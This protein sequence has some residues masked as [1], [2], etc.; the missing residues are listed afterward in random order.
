MTSSEKD[1]LRPISREEIYG[2]VG[3]PTDVLK[4]LVPPFTTEL[5]EA[6]SKG[7]EA[8]QRKAELELIGTGDKPQVLRYKIERPGEGLALKVTMEGDWRDAPEVPRGLPILADFEGTF[9]RRMRPD[10]DPVAVEGKTLEKD[11]AYAVAQQG[12]TNIWYL[13]LPPN[14]FPNGGV[15]TKFVFPDGI[16]VIRGE[17]ILLY[18]DPL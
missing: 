5:I 13:R 1:K 3:A 4:V 6:I 17:S 9:F 11:G 18:V 7:L 15:I 16:D 14:N 12:K 8:G 2:K 10:P